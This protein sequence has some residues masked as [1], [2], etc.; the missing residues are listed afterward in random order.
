MKLNVGGIRL[1]LG[2]VVDSQPPV[3]STQNGQ[4]GGHVAARI[5]AETIAGH[6]VKAL[7][8]GEMVDPVS[9]SDELLNYGI[10]L[11]TGL[12]IGQCILRF[13]F[14][15]DGRLTMVLGWLNTQANLHVWEMAHRI[16]APELFFKVPPGIFEA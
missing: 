2:T 4:E 12:H 6:T 15:D 7:L 11:G 3:S 9:A 13:L 5:L 14:P 16:P 1:K 8:E 10:G